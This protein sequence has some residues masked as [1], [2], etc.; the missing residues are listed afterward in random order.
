MKKFFFSIIYFSMGFT[1]LKI[2]QINEKNNGI[3]I[4]KNVNTISPFNFAWQA[5]HKLLFYVPTKGE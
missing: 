3:N 5:S 4:D 2:N 1:D